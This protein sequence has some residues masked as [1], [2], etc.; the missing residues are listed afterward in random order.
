MLFV[1]GIT[2]HTGS[3]FAERLI[4]ESFAGKIRAVTRSVDSPILG[5]DALDI[6]R[7][8]GDLSNLDFLTASMKGVDTVLHIASI[9]TTENVIEAAIRNKVRWIICVHT[10]GRFSKYKSASEEYIR[11]EDGILQRRNEID[12]TIVRPTMIYGSARD[13]NMI[14]LVEY[15]HKNKFFPMFGSGQNLMQPVHARDL[16]NAYYDILMNRDITANKEYDLAGKQPLPYIDLVHT[17]S[18]VLHRNTT[19]VK[20]PLWFSIL[21]A[22]I[23]NVISSNAKIKVEQVLR[24]QED[25]AFSYALASKDFGYDP[26]SFQEG[27]KEEVREYLLSLPA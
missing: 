26:I 24:M 25:K 17:V 4:R 10:T 16:G 11:I 1:T 22:K 6:E 23:Y 14:K 21:S 20:L 27:I 7:V 5:E 13:R 12:I 19:I 2:G 3:F 8:I 18:D 9:K 15:M